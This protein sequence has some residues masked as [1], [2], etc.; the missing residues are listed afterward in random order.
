MQ[1]FLVLLLVTSIVPAFALYEPPT[2]EEKNIFDQLLSQ[3]EIV[4]APKKDVSDVIETF[5]KPVVNT[6][7]CNSHDVNN[8]VVTMVSTKLAKFDENTVHQDLVTGG[9]YTWHC[10]ETTQ[11]GKITLE[12]NNE[13][14]INPKVITND[15]KMDPQLA[16]VENLVILYHE[17]LHGQLM[18]DAMKNSTYGNRKFVINNQ[19]KI[20]IIPMLILII[21]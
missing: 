18:I 3:F 15:T 11:N 17:L 14:R 2:T 7:S 10:L 8:Q 5:Q 13:L 6:F 12:C 4:D 20:S 19:K 9:S 21:K 1:D 16:N